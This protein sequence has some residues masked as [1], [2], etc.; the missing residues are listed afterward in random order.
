MKIITEPEKRR[1]RALNILVGVATFATVI[2][3]GYALVIVQSESNDAWINNC[4]EKYGEG[5][6]ETKTASWEERCNISHH[7]G[8]LP[9]P[10]IGQ[11]IV[12]KPKEK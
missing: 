2:Y 3:A 8:S 4:N 6:W 5:N 9:V 10:Y 1:K 7:I 12:C 11:V